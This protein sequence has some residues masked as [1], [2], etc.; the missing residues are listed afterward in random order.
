MRDAGYRVVWTPEATLVHLEL[1]TRG[2]DASPASIA[3]HQSEQAMV[4]HR[5]GRLA[6]T[7]PFLNPALAATETA[8]VLRPTA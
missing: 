7:D 1:A 8:I 5:W 2:R 4:R 3:R 6:E